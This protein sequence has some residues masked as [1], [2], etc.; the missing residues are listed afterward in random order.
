MMIINEIIH[1]TTLSHSPK[2]NSKEERKNITFIELI[3]VIMLNSGDVSH[4]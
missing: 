3:V 2:M 1:E 4:K